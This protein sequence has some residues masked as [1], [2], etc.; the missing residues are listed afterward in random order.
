MTPILYPITLTRVMTLRVMTPYYRVLYAIFIC[1]SASNKWILIQ[2]GHMGHFKG[3]ETVMI[4]VIN[5]SDSLIKN[6]C[7]ESRVMTRMFPSLS[8]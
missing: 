5:E 7:H 2:Y 6:L 3:V 1:I 8:A 4:R